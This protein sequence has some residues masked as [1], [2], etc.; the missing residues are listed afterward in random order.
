MLLSKISD[1]FEAIGAAVAVTLVCGVFAAFTSLAHQLE[2]SNLKLQL[3]VSDAKVANLTNK[4]EDM[5]DETDLAKRKYAES[6][7]A[8]EVDKKEAQR[9]IAQIK[10]TKAS[11]C[12]EV[13]AENW[14]R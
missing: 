11:S 6:L 14:G 2:V 12:A 3:S 10:A 8:R 13:L 5:V 9:R 4:L 7:V 1:H